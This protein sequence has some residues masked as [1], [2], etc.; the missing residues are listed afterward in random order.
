MGIGGIIG[1]L[2]VG[3]IAMRAGSA[4]PAMIQSGG[5]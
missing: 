3:S 1:G 2:I 4:V 5:V